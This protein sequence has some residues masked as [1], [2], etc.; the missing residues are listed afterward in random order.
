MVYTVQ[1]FFI[2]AL[3]FCTVPFMSAMKKPL[4]SEKTRLISLTVNDLTKKIKAGKSL[5]RPLKKELPSLVNM[6]DENG[7]LAVV[8]CLDENSTP[9]LE[10]LLKNGAFIDLNDAKGASAFSISHTAVKDLK[11]TDFDDMG[12]VSIYNVRTLLMKYGRIYALEEG[13][14]NH[15]R[16]SKKEAINKIH[17]LYAHWWLD[18]DVK[19]ILLSKTILEKSDVACIRANAKRI[20]KQLKKAS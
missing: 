19:K 13:V 15:L 2:V 8:L 10:L 20:Y 18:N 7:N 1:R 17:A 5:S 16:L 6:P 4:K 11:D 14:K 3:L 9:C 12:Y